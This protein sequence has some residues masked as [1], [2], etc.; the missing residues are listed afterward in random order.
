MVVKRKFGIIHILI[1]GFLIRLTVIILSAS[2]TN[3]DLQS[4]RL[5]GE[6]TRQGKNIYPFPGNFHHPYFPVMLYVEALASFFG[7]YQTIF[8]KIIFSLFDTGIIFL[9][10]L[11]TPKIPVLRNGRGPSSSLFEGVGRRKTRYQGVKFSNLAFIYAINPISILIT[12]FHGQFDAIPLFFLLLALYFFLRNK[13]STLPYLFLSFAI[14]IKTWPILFSIPFLRRLKNAQQFLLATILLISF[15]LLSLLLYSFLF[16]GNPFIILLTLKAYRPVFGVFGIGFLTKYIFHIQ[17]IKTIS[18]LTY[19]F[20]IAF[21]A[22]SFLVK[23]KVAIEE[24]FSQLLFFFILT[25]VFGI[26]W[27]MWLVPFFLI[28][29]PQGTWMFFII[30]TVYLLVSYALWLGLKTESTSLIGG[31]FV[32]L[33]LIFISWQR[34]FFQ[35]S[36]IESPVGVKNG[37]KDR[38]SNGQAL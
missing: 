32:W 26:Q 29:R 21:F 12:S 19:V 9:V 22:Y 36:Q 38:Q 37:L 35:F 28:L 33:S 20:L 3:Y 11:L 34:Y 23:K 5:I 30:A 17:V 18:Q 16:H 1:L 13:S 15:P 24:L 27:L 2:I 25:P 14:A 6:L 7:Q 4:Y 8:L 31:I 10:Y